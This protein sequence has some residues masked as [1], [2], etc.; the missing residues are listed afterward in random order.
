[1]RTQSD[2]AEMENRLDKGQMSSTVWECVGVRKEEREK[3]T[4]STDTTLTQSQAALEHLG[5]NVLCSIIFV[6]VLL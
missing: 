2:V 5:L 4:H 6:L 3:G 1:M